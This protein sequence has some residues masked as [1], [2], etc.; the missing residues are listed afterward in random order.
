MRINARASYIQKQNICIYLPFVYCISP[1]GDLKPLTK[2]ERSI[3]AFDSMIENE[4]FK[5]LI[6]RPINSNQNS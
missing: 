3:F 5:P 2:I 1:F 6:K 4:L